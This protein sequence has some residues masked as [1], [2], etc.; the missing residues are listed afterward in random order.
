[1]FSCGTPK[2]KVREINLSKRNFDD[3]IFNVRSSKLKFDSSDG[4]FKQIQNHDPNYRMKG[5][6]DEL[7]LLNSEENAL[8]KEILG[9]EERIKMFKEK[10]E[11]ANKK[12][13]MMTKI[14]SID[15]NERDYIIEMKSKL[16]QA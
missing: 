16:P 14:L 6:Q 13:E 11:Q 2:I 7:D 5:N 4:S 9:K 1:M 8:K 12:L 10:I 3:I 15:I